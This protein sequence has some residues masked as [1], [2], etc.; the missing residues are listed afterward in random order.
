MK[1]NKINLIILGI[2]IVSVIAGYS[3]YSQ[4][5]IIEPAETPDSFSYPITEKKGLANDPVYVGEKVNEFLIDNPKATEEYAQDIIYHDIAIKEKDNS[6][7]DKIKDGYWKG[8]CY[9]LLK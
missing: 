8:H 1:F 3:Y 9:R 6:I 7:C 4:K 2:I 5:L